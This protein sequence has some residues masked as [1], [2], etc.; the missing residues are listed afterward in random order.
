[1]AAAVAAQLAL[2][3]EPWPDAR[4]CPRVRMALHAGTAEPHDGDYLAG[5]LNRLA[6]LTDA[7]HGG[8]ILLSQTVGG[9]AGEAL[10][11]G[12][13]LRP[14]GEYRLRDILQ[15]EEVFQLLH[16]ALPATFPP[17]NAPATSPTT[18]PCIRP[19]S[20]AASAKSTRSSRSCSSPASG[21]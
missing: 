17:L 5:C 6:R 16:P 21:W 4:V 20:W 1:V 13:G 14:L 9:L 10:P 18:C 2:L 3:A 15:P 12:V 8:Q 7:A 19:R 11:A